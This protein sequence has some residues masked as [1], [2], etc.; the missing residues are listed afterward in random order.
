[1]TVGKS[2][3]ATE[4]SG[5]RRALPQT[6]TIL[7]PDLDGF[8]LSD[9][10]SSRR[11]AWT[12]MTVIETGSHLFFCA[13]PCDAVPVPLRAFDSLETMHLFAHTARELS[14]ADD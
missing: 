2:N 14:A 1:L 11:V 4:V 5:L 6:D 13:E 3:Q 7:D 8:T 9:N 12:A 10:G